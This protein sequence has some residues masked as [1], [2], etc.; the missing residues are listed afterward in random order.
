MIEG[1]FGELVMPV[2][3]AASD[4]VLSSKEWCDT[5]LN[6]YLLLASMVILI[7]C[8]RDYFFVSGDIAKTLERWRWAFT[9][10]SNMTLSRAR[11]ICF[12]SMILPLVLVISFYM[13]PDKTIF[14]ALGLAIAY[15][16]S[17]AFIYLCVKPRLERAGVM[18][19]ER[20]NEKTQLV[21]LGNILCI[22]NLIL[23]IVKAP[24]GVSR[25]VVL[26]M[27]LLLYLIYI[28]RKFQILH[29]ELHTFP[30]ILYLCALEISPLVVSGWLYTYYG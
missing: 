8:I 3:K 14:H 25:M 6:R 22:A 23:W 7:L 24:Y 21:I 28:V 4:I 20:N 26:V 18:K 5:P 12:L 19:T 15:Y 2:E 13:I 30:T 10:E 17:K 29:S 16:F 1:L 11:N 9:L 27:V